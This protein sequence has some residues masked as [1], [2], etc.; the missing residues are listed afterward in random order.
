MR[1]FFS[2]VC[3]AVLAVLCCVGCPPMPPTPPGPSPD[4]DAGLP[5]CQV[6]CQNLMT[7]GCPE[8]TRYGIARCVSTCE[9]VQAT[10]FV[11]LDVACLVKA[12][13]A[14]AVKMCAVRCDIPPA[15]K[16]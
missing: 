11:D 15:S 8:A 3:M 4:S 7:I 16:N 10:H 1:Q 5:S 9:H 2:F 13:T 14:F 6:A 12:E